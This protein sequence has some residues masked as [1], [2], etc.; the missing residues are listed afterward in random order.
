MLETQKNLGN[1]T[2]PRRDSERPSSWAKL[3]GTPLGQCEFHNRP[4]MA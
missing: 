1:V 4:A 2:A 3:A